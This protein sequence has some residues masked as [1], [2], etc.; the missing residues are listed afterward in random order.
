M[1]AYRNFSRKGQGLGD[2][3]SADREPITGGWI[4]PLVRGQST[5]KL[6]ALKHLCA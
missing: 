2:M 1:D 4:E 5:L 3:A 6:K